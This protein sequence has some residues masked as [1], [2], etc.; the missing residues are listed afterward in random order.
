[1]QSLEVN[2]G[3]FRSGILALFLSLAAFCISQSANAQSAGPG[4]VVVTLKAQKVQRAPD[5]KEVLKVADRAM[6]G[7]V[8]QYDA[9]YKNQGKKGVRNLEPTL[10]IPRGLEY[11]PNS[12]HPA[13]AKASL[14]GKNFAPIPLKRQVSMPDGQTREELIPYSEY[15]A[16]RWEVGDLEAGRTATISARAVLALN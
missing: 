5:G 14:D 8:I 7:E 16:L 15:R 12:A 2:Y 10:P 1:M 9:L 3:R 13:P 4:D 11:L 6:P